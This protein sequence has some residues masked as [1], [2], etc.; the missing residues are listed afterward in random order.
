[1]HALSLEAGDQVGDL[2]DEVWVVCEVAEDVSASEQVLRVA[3][4]C[5]G[6]G[7]SLS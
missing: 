7:G 5:L 1:V 3:G 2:G 6:K 4:S